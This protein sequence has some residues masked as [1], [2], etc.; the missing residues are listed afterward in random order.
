MEYNVHEN[1][2]DYIPYSDNLNIHEGDNIS[3]SNNI[4]CSDNLNIHESN[5][6]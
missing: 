4:L 2:S 3:C 6:K 1:G 5:I